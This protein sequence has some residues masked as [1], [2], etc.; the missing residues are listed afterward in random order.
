MSKLRVSAI[1]RGCVYDGPGVR[2]T[3]FLKGCTLHCPW[4]CN[5]EN[6][7]FKQ[8]WFIDDS[9][10]IKHKGIVSEL[11]A[12]CK[13]N[14]GD[15]AIKKCPFSVAE[16][17]CHDWLPAELFLQI[18]KDKELYGKSG[19]V[20]FSGGEPLMQADALLPVLEMCKKQNLNIAFET[21]LFVSKKNIAVIIPYAD[22]MIVDLKLQPEQRDIPNYINCISEN[23]DLIKK[24]GINIF[25]RLV[26]VNSLIS[27]KEKIC[28]QLKSL[29]VEEIELLKCHHLGA[30]KY[31]K[32]NK[33][34]VDFTADER[35]FQN[36][37]E[38]LQSEQLI[39]T[40]LKV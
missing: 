21:T 19:G 12:S 14:H 32:L 27:I 23:L 3:I 13:R 30:R 40:Q 29:G 34:S 28:K 2:T 17:V 24:Q 10:C 5:P 39:V 15:R 4:C 38:Y 8:E 37:S 7:S 1:Q 11:C 25:Y 26:F 33:E 16:P 9:K 36:F 6:I 20:T 35:L 18:E 22:I 31:E